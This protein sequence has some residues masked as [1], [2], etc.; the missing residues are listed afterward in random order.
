MMQFD[1]Q[2]GNGQSKS[3][4]LGFLLCGGGPIERL[5][6]LVNVIWSDAW[7]DITHGDLNF[8]GGWLITIRSTSVSTV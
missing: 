1:E 4:S 2:L 5:K 6:N 3:C 8:I 7:P